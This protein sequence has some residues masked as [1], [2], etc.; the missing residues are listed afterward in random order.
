LTA[1]VAS[2]ESSGNEPPLL[3]AGNV[4]LTALRLSGFKKPGTTT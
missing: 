3:I 2:T 4:A 1:A